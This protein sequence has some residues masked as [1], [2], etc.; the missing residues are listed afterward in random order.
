MSNLNVLYK[1]RKFFGL[2]LFLFGLNQASFAQ[3]Y[4]SQLTGLVLDTNQAPLAY[5]DIYLKTNDEN[6]KIGQTGIDGYFRIP[7]DNGNYNLVFSKIEFR[8]QEFA[9]LCQNGKSDTVII[10]MIPT[11]ESVETVYVKTKWKDPGPSYMRKAIDRRDVWASRIPSQSST[12]FIKAFEE[13]TSQ[14]KNKYKSTQ[15]EGTASIA[16]EFGADSKKDSSEPLVNA[17]MAEVIM[18]R[19]WLPPNKLKEVRTA[20]K[21]RGDKSGLFYLTT[22]D[23]DFNIYQNLLSLP[24]LSPLPIMSPLSNSA[25]LA[26][27]FRFIKSYVDSQHGRTLIIRFDGRQTSNAT[28][29]GE[30]HLVDT[31]FYVSKLRLNIPQ[32]LMAEYNSMRLTQSYRLTKDSLILIDSQTFDYT[33]KSGS[34]LNLGNTKVIYSNIQVNPNFPKKHFGL[35]LSKTDQE[36]YDKDTAFWKQN[37]AI[38]L[39]VIEEKFV[40]QTD[41]I[42]RVHN[43]D[44]YLDSIERLI[45]KVTFKSLVLEGQ[46]FQDRRKG[47]QMGF[48][49]LWITYQPWWPGGGRGV[50]F[51][52]LEKTFENK[53]TVRLVP[54]L[55]YGVLNRDIRGNI[56]FTTLYNPYKQKRIWVQVGRD[57]GFINPFA[58]YVDV[59]RRDNF[60]Q[61]DHLTAYHR[62]EIVNGLYLRLRAEISDR[63]DIS[64]YRFAASGDSLFENNTAVQ[65]KSHR[66]VFGSITLS[67]TPFQK[68]ISEPRRKVIL[69]SA[70]PTFAVTYRKSLPGILQS[71][72]D[73]DYLEYTIEHDFPWGLLG[74]SEIKANSGAFLNRRNVSLI[75]YRYQRRSDPLIFTPPMFAFQTLDSTFTTFKRFYEVHYRHHFNGA[76]LNKIPLVKKLSL[77]ESVGM[78]ILYAPE[79]RNMFFIEAYAGIDKVVRIWRERYKIGIYY[80]VGHSNLFNRPVAQFKINLQNYDRLNNKW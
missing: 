59:F 78:N 13:V 75:D 44:D 3:I 37:R 33:S 73:L 58:A 6:R 21:I 23:G 61:H 1:M 52:A 31:A 72:I 68:Y 16:A 51:C 27:R 29:N 43:S 79:R 8:E 7:F 39:T 70:W 55:S 54:N 22:L 26:Y 53:K 47:I 56:I 49:P 69:G 15:E 46:G 38:P 30:I 62:Q 60:Y 80:C 76:I 48:Q 14:R 42:E 25:L 66:A 12:V 35:E 24:A 28:F 18:T 32:H 65:F 34:T 67:Y 41:S 2:I 17:N 4:K 11:V 74:N 10:K 40:T 71:T 36:A 64:S 19:D 63:K 9:Y 50:F 77:Y 5:V 57:F 45:N 20:V